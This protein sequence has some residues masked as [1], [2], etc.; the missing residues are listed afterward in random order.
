MARLT[1]NGTCS[2]KALARRIC[3][4]LVQRARAHVSTARHNAEDPVTSP[5]RRQSFSQ[6]AGIAR[7]DSHSAGSII[8]IC[9]RYAPLGPHTQSPAQVPS[10][11]NKN[12]LHRI[13]HRLS[14][15]VKIVRAVSLGCSLRA[16]TNGG[17]LLTDLR[18]RW[19]VPGRGWSYRRATKPGSAT[20]GGPIINAFR[21][22][23]QNGINFSYAHQTVDSSGYP[24]TE[25]IR[26]SLSREGKLTVRASKLVAGPAKIMNQ[27]ELVCELRDGAKFV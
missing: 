15:F 16:A 2:R 26:H 8:I 13:K 24:V 23:A 1:C 21:V 7:S 14:T 10:G 11:N 6:F 4:C 25:Y 18:D 19:G 22:T 9:K 3:R 12:W 20:Q 5:P 27:G 17:P